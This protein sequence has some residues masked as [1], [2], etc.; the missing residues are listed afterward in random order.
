M[1]YLA[2]FTDLL[3]T[4]V[5][6]I[7]LLSIRRSR[8]QINEY[9]FRIHSLFTVVIVFAIVLSSANLFEAI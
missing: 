9:K 8:K 3:I 4:A 5:L 2:V 7:G 1:I 6:V